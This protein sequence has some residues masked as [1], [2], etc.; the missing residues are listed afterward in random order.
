M[1]RTNCKSCNDDICNCDSTCSCGCGE[2][3]QCDENC[4]CGCHSKMNKERL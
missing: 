1:N 3:C 4:T 2:N